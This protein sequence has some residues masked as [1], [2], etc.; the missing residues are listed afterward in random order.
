VSTTFLADIFVDCQIAQAG[1]VMRSL[2]RESGTS[3]F[4][5]FR[6]RHPHAEKIVP[7]GIFLLVQ[8]E[9]GLSSPHS[10]PFTTNPKD[11][12]D[13]FA[14]RVADSMIAA[15]RRVVGAKPAIVVHILNGDRA[16]WVE[17]THEGLRL[18]S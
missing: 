18:V 14:T 15:C 13:A 11:A 16:G 9:V 10:Q 3:M 12:L 1:A 7:H 4:H 17:R 2:R 8:Q 5:V 6:K